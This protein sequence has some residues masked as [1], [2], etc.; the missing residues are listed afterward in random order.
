MPR[1]H[2]PE[3]RRRAVELA[4]L[5]DKP[6]SQIAAELGISDSCLRNWVRQAEIDDGHRPGLS[7]DERAELVALRRKNRVLE[8]EVEILKRASAYFA[9]ENVLPK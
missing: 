3:F 8:L 6:K 9:R 5:G 4:L 7:S 2:P 1:P